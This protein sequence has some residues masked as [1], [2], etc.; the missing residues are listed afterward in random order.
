MTYEQKYVELFNLVSTKEITLLKDLERKIWIAKKAKFEH[1]V[2]SELSDNSIYK[3]FSALE[4]KRFYILIPFISINN[5]I[6][7]PYLILSQQIL[8][9]RYSDP[10]LLTNYINHKIEYSFDL[11]NINELEKYHIVFKYKQ[12][13][14]DFTKYNEFK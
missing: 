13:E 10:M 14:F 9:S 5:K 2:F 7:E 6:D 8:I 12:I 4:R 11:F 3:F 1:A